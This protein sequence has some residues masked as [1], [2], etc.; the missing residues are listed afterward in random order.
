[1]WRW[2]I[3]GLCAFVLYKLFI[4]DKKHKDA[5]VGSQSSGP[6]AGPGEEM[7]KDP[8]CGAYVS[9]EGNIRVR[10]GENVLHFC[11]YDCRDKYVQQLE[12]ARPSIQGQD[13]D[14]A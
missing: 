3:I 2:I 14:Q 13:S 1:M 5:K 4:G 6:A 8:V 10:N 11:S 9:K 7:V 12:A